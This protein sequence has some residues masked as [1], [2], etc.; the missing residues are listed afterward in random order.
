MNQLDGQSDR[1]FGAAKTGLHDVFI[2]AATYEALRNVS[3]DWLR[4]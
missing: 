3:Q 1:L 4:K 2:R